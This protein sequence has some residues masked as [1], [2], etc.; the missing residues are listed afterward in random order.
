VLPLALQLNEISR[1]QA[2]DP[3]C[4]NRL[5]SRDA[6]S[7]FDL[8]YTGILVRK[9][10][11]DGVEQIV[12]PPSLRPRVLHLEHLPRVAG[13]QVVTRMFRSLR[14]HYFWEHMASDVANTVKN[15]TV[16]A[17]TR[18]YEL[19]WTIF[20][21]LFPASETLEYVEVDV[22]GPLPKTEHGNRFLLVMTGRF[23]KLT[24][25][26]PLR[27]ISAFKVARAFCEKR[28][29]VYGAPRYVLTD[30]GTQFSAKFLLAVCREL[31]IG[32]LFITGYHPQTNGQ[33]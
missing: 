6:D 10:P 33:V 22:L 14:R 8:N 13:H 3:W 16:C 17:K 30:N 1:E 25:T 29:F 9:A 7:L 2:A 4:R 32:K 18:I 27:S 23:S 12:V 19:N 24:R 28:V 5:S 21:K 15:C 31:G 20:L 26:V 11:L